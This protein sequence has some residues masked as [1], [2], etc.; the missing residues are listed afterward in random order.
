MIVAD[1]ITIMR[2]AIFLN[3]ITTYESHDR[4]GYH[5]NN[6][7]TYIFVDI[8]TISHTIFMDITMI[9]C[10]TINV[11]IIMM[12]YKILVDIITISHTIF[13]DTI[14]MSHARL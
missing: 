4:C 9:T 7:K 2:Y 1:I 5:Y 8:I 12:S 6:N 3:T 14:A 13:L 11:D 10:R